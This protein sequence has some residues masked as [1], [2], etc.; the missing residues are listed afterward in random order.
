LRINRKVDT[1][2]PE[3]GGLYRRYFNQGL[4]AWICLPDWPDKLFSQAFPAAKD[5][6]WKNWVTFL[7]SYNAQQYDFLIHEP[8]PVLLLVDIRQSFLN[9][10]LSG[11]PMGGPGIWLKFVWGDSIMWAWFGAKHGIFGATYY[12]WKSVLQRID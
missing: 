2:L 11:F 6:N 7:E 10:T 9:P 12:D 4:L 8:S 3:I 1:S 5:R